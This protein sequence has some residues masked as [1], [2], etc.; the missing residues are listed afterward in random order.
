[1]FTQ[2]PPGHYRL[3]VI[4]ANSHGVWNHRG[5][6]IEF[7]VA[8]HYWQ[9]WWFAASAALALLVG[10]WLAVRWHV[11]QVARRVRSQAA[12]R[13]NEREHIARDIHDTLLQGMQGAVMR[14][15]AITSR[16]Q[17]PDPNRKELEQVSTGPMPSLL[18]ANC[19]FITCIWRAAQPT[20]MPC[21]S[22]S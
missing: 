2:L 10:L 21:C 16:M 7:D 1:M 5:Q 14:V 11:A 20:S 19:A 4:G 17:A 6:T 15:Q 13:T 22:R 9:T 8:P 3:E 18:R 12:E